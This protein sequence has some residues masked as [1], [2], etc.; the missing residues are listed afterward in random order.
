[1]SSVPGRTQDNAVYDAPYGRRIQELVNETK[2]G[3]ESHLPSLPSAAYMPKNADTIKRISSASAKT[4]TETLD[5][6]SVYSSSDD[7]SADLLLGSFVM[8]SPTGW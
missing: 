3:R 8:T 5:A 1:M 6:L 7:L 2:K 4:L